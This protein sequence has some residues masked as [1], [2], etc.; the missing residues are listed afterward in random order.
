MVGTPRLEGEPPR[1][2]FSGRH[3]GQVHDAV[4][5]PADCHDQSEQ[6][7]WRDDVGSA[8]LGGPVVSQRVA[9]EVAERVT[10]G[11]V[12]VVPVDVVVFD[13][14]PRSVD[15]VVVRM[16]PFDRPGPCEMEII[17]GGAY[18]LGVLP[19][20]NVVRKS[21]NVGPEERLKNFPL[22]RPESDGPNALGGEREAQS[23]EIGAERCVSL[24]HLPGQ[25]GHD[26]VARV[27]EQPLWWCLPQLVGQ[28]LVPHNK[29]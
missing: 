29:I 17:P 1:S 8:V 20:C 2:C 6:S 9:A 24:T 19:S 3:R 5:A 13:Q 11:G 18:H 25:Y 10:P 14:D 21:L 15:P 23:A 4:D 22:V 16:T 28:F 7:L 12:D 27:P 26:F